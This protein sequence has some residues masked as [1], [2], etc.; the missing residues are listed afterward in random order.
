MI[1]KKEEITF[2]ELFS[3]N[4][5]LSAR[6]KKSDSGCYSLRSKTQ[7]FHFSNQIKIS[8]NMEK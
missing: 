3:K 5:E 7:P 6:P 4:F 2:V 8:E 1:N